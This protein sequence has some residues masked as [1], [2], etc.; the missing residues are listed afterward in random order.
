MTRII[1]IHWKAEELPERV[2]R[3]ESAGYEVDSTL[4]QGSASLR[5]LGEDPPAALVIDLSRLPSHGRD[6]AISVRTRKSTRR[7]PLVFV[8]GAPDKVARVK[9]FL[10][11]AVYTA[12]EDIGSAVDVAIAGPPADPVIPASVFAAYKG[13]PLVEKLGIKS[14]FQVALHNPP[15]DFKKT[16][17]ALP[18]RVVLREGGG[19]DRDLS[20]WFTRSV[21]ELEQ[22]ISAMAEG[23]GDKPMW[24]AWPKKSSKVATDLTQQIVR[25]AGLASGLVDYKICAI[26]ETWSGL[27]FKKR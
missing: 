17:G 2:A 27:L 11:D 23:V 8:G 18:N 9:E 13:K 1:L 7:I 5:R 14:G 25:E 21:E 10:P 12:W 22:D 15:E 24:I 20:I 19:D 4:P 3:L 16:L 6:V 26:D